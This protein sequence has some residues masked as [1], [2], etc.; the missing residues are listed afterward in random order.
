M[1]PIITKLH[2]LEVSPLRHSIQ[3]RKTKQIFIPQTYLSTTFISYLCFQY[4]HVAGIS[5]RERHTKQS[6]YKHHNGH[7]GKTGI[8]R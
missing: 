2:N 1:E 7:L 4:V 3:M 6:R 8:S 5:D